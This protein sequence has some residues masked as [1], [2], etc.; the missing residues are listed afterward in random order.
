MTQKR[1]FTL[2]ELLVKG[3]HL[4]CD[5]EKPAHGQGKARFTLIE[6]L[7]VIAIIAILAAI[8][9]PALNS[10]RERGRVA[11]C[12]NNMKQLGL[13]GLQYCD[14]YD[15][16][17]VSGSRNSRLNNQML[18]YQNFF[19]FYG[20]RREN[21]FCASGQTKQEW[22][23]GGNEFP[24]KSGYPL[25]Y[26]VNSFLHHR[27]ETTGVPGDSRCPQKITQV[28]NPSG[29]PYF[30]EGKG[31]GNH[32]G[33]FTALWDEYQGGRLTDAFTAEEYGNVNEGVSPFAL[34]HKRSGN[35]TYVDGHVEPFGAD[36]AL[37]IAR[38]YPATN[39]L[40]FTLEGKLP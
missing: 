11:N 37:A 10:A 39:A 6:L 31:A 13:Y 19:N 29:V 5:R 15:G 16:F 30:F 38:Y 33:T 24:D 12:L 32:Y 28:K 8:L 35:I 9:L 23:S 22:T 40:N 1:T 25:H 21:V 34:W 7:V 27:N 18:W 4:C 17:F 36:V 3:S 20:L 2:I 14:E 26:M